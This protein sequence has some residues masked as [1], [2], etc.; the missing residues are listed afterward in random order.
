MKLTAKIKLCPTQEQFNLLLN[1]LEKANDACNYISELAWENKI[2]SRFQLHHLVYYKVRE[3]FSLSSNMVICCIAKVSRTY[4]IENDNQHKFKTFAAFPYNH[5]LFR[6]KDDKTL[7]IWTV[8]GR[9]DIEFKIGEN[10]KKLLDGIYG[11]SALCLI[12]GKFYLYIS[13]EIEDKERIKVSEYLGV[14]L[15]LVN[16]AVDSDGVFYTGKHLN[17]VRN[18]YSNLR[19]RLQR[20]DTKSAKRLLKRI[21]GKESLFSKD[22]NHCISKK[23]VES[24]KDT[25]RGIAIEDLKGIHFQGTASKALRRLLNFWSFNDLRKKIEYKAKLAGIPVAVVRPQCTSQICPSCGWGHKKNRKS[26]KKFKCVY[27]GF[28]GNADHIA[29][30][31]IGRRAVVNQPYVGGEVTKGILPIA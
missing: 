16:I 26:Q 22:V 31:N 15:G 1:T 10:Y 21:S 28:S 8:N 5:H 13:C 27:C 17:N 12:D 29:A 24:A 18:R 30:I 3:K 2:F 23:I 19:A 11:E 4:K 7:N 6:F 25:E 9:Q 20:K 14:D